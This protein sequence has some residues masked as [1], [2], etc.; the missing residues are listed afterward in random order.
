MKTNIN[1]LIDGS[2]MAAKSI[3]QTN[4]KDALGLVVSCVGRKLVMKDLT[5]EE[6]EAIED[7]IGTNVHLTGFYSYGELSPFSSDIRNCQLHN[8]TM[9]LTVLYED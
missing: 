8:Q 5:D 9:T 4:N 2:E 7:T 6:L 1:G 3:V